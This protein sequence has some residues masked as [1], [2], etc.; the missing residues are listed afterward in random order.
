[1]DRLQALEN[2]KYITAP[3]DGVVTARETDIGALINAGSGSGVELFKVADIH[4]MRVYVR[5]PQAYASQLRHGMEADLKLA[6][7]PHQSLQ[8]QTGDDFKRDQQRIAHRAC[9]TDGG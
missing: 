6:Q 5:V 8:G 4:Q 3:F 2:F 1:M 7:Y 9:R